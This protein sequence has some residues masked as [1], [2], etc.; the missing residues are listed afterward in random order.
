MQGDHSTDRLNIADVLLTVQVITSQVV[1]LY[2][3]KDTGA[4][5][6]CGFSL[7]KLRMKSDL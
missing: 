6:T 5:V 3:C 1:G 7:Q 2:A 4:A